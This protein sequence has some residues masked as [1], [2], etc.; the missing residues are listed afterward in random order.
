MQKPNWH[1]FLLLLCLLF[2]F[3]FARPTSGQ[4]K[5][6]L[7]Q[8]KQN[9]LEAKSLLMIWPESM[10]LREADLTAR[11]AQLTEL[12]ARMNARE[13]ALQKSELSL[14]ERENLLLQREKDLQESLTLI[15][16]LK[17]SLAIASKSL[18]ELTLSRNKWR[19]T[20]F[21]APVVAISLGLVIG[22]FLA[23]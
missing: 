20:A 1:I 17:S 14:L 18:T 7:Q 15:T 12:E 5:S 16:G 4:E 13:A 2:L 23:P 8:L 6:S 9:L 11:E 19:T 3:C 10:K 22:S 21:I